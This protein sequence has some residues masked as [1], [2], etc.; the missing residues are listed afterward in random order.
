MYDVADYE[1]DAS[2]QLDAIFKTSD[3]AVMVGGSGLFIQAVL[4]GLSPMP[5]VSD[6]IREKWRKIE[7]MRALNRCKRR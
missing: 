6:S 3:H 7:P 4:Y 5:P 2:S 1:R